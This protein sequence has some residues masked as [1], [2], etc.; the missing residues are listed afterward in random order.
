MWIEQYDP[1]G[2]PC[3]FS[4][5]RPPSNFLHFIN[6]QHIWQRAIVC[7]INYYHQ[8]REPPKAECLWRRAVLIN[9]NY[10][11][12]RWIS[13]YILHFNNS[14]SSLRVNCCI[15]I[16]SIMAPTPF[17]NAAP[18]VDRLLSLT[19]VWRTVFTN[20]HSPCDSHI[21]HNDLIRFDSSANYVVLP[22]FYVEH[23]HDPLNTIT[24]N[25]H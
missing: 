25:V 14:G 24:N 6:N 22:I 18:R 23:V 15:C 19:I 5:S 11:P 1:L 21:C 7:F 16:I 10:L 4:G 3:A 20:L 9:C 12:S 8:F 13:P 17:C 2:T